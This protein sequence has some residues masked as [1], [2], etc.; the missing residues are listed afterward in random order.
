MIV[1][2]GGDDYDDY[3]DDRYH[4]KGTDIR[5]VYIPELKIMATY[6]DADMTLWTLVACRTLLH[7]RV[8]NR[9]DTLVTDTATVSHRSSLLIHVCS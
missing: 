9:Y 6:L 5:G 1:D 7:H 8:D 4:N 3:D 2:D